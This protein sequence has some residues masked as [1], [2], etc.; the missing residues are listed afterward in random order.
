MFNFDGKTIVGLVIASFAMV[1]ICCFVAMFVLFM[2][3]N[4]TR[5]KDYILDDDREIFIRIENQTQYKI[6]HLWLGKN[7]RHTIHYSK[8]S[9]NKLSDYI[10][11]TNVP[12]GYNGISITFDVDGNNTLVRSNIIHSV[13]FPQEYLTPIRYQFS[14]DRD[15]IEGEGLIGGYYTYVIT[16]FLPEDQSIEYKII[17]DK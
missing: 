16:N 4:V 7:H 3:S 17:K 12:V 6:E 13:D 14:K 15:I 1:V 8:I 11:A 2:L 9:V 10:Q 5:S